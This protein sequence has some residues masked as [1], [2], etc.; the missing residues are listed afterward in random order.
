MTAVLARSLLGVLDEWTERFE[1][2]A[3]ISRRLDLR[4]A[5]EEWSAILTR[6]NPDTGE[7][8]QGIGTGMTMQVAIERALAEFDVNPCAVCAWARACGDP[9]GEDCHT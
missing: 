6:A 2:H 7:V 1:A 8:E 5:P 9:P 4:I 3:M